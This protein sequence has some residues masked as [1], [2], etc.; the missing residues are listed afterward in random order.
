MIRFNLNHFHYL[1]LWKQ[2]VLVNAYSLFKVTLMKNLTIVIINGRIT[3]Q[4]HINC[5]SLNPCK[6]FPSAEA[7]PHI[8]HFTYNINCLCK[9]CVTFHF[10]Y[11]THTKCHSVRKQGESV[12]S[13]CQEHFLKCALC[14]LSKYRCYYDF[15][16]VAFISLTMREKTKCNMIYN[17]NCNTL[18]RADLWNTRPM[19]IKRW[20]DEVLMH[21]CEIRKKHL[22]HECCKLFGFCVTFTWPAVPSLLESLKAAGWRRRQLSWPCHWSLIVGLELT[23]ACRWLVRLCRHLAGDWQEQ[24]LMQ[25]RYCSWEG[26]RLGTFSRLPPATHTHLQALPNTDRIVYH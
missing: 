6:L 14:C 19:I 16:V 25:P 21:L 22:I 9:C 8:L 3:I 18:K 12:R 5:D 23:Q 10:Q 20:E 1:P 26:N 4:S 24:T 13:E 7:Y 2:I 15:I 11:I 17:R